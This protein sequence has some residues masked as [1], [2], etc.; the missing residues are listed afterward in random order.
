MTSG[1]A[2]RPA[3]QQIQLLQAVFAPSMEARE[4]ALQAW[5]AG[6]EFSRLQ[7]T[8][9]PLLPLLYF[10]MK[11][12]PSFRYADR[13]RGIYRRTWYHNH[14]LRQ[15]MIPVLDSLQRAGISPLLLGGTALAFSVY[16]QIGLRMLPGGAALLLDVEQLQTAVPL[17]AALN[18]RLSTPGDPKP[19]GR[20]LPEH[21]PLTFNNP[22]Q[23]KISITWRALPD[24]WGEAGDESFLSAARSVAIDGASVRVM[25][26]TDMLLYAC[27][28]RTAMGAWPG[29]AWIA[30]CM[31]ILETSPALD[32]RRLED[33]TSARRLDPV[34]SDSLEFIRRELK[35]AFPDE[36]LM[37]LKGARLPR[38]AQIE[39]TTR[40][41][42]P[43]E[44]NRMT[45]I[46]LLYLEYAR[47][48]GA[49]SSW[50]RLLN[51]PNYL[52]SYRHRA[53][54]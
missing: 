19:R 4:T 50:Q 43:R 11:K 31:T 25:N 45:K 10:R 1:G 6:G 38:T 2:W 32:W 48:S 44:I 33:Q 46:W 26:R 14:L 17:L 3:W 24:R 41:R 5:L 27:A 12:S 28:A 36:H 7:E 30:D 52:Q 22:E 15:R 40:L 9:Y 49:K 18:W 21:P 20:F 54:S 42:P 35:A 13:L 23:L 16:P 37:Q 51:F 47:T 29:L 8:G 34:V 39:Y 53:K